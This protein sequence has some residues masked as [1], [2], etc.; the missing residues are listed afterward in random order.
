[1]INQS[2]EH[3]MN[4][5]ACLRDSAAGGPWTAEAFPCLDCGRTGDVAAIDDQRDAVSLRHASWRR[6]NHGLWTA[7]AEVVAFD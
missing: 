3:S 6:A 1:M 4:G 7:K 5:C 2:I